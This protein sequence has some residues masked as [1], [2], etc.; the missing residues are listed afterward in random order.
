MA[1][2][3]SRTNDS[4]GGR[5]QEEALE[6][7]AVVDPVPTLTAYISFYPHTGTGFHSALS[8]FSVD[9]IQVNLAYFISPGRRG[10]EGHSFRGSTGAHRNLPG[11]LSARSRARETRE[12]YAD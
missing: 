9:R 3:E 7:L 2:A 4:N 6:L 11:R 5:V 12:F 10:A 8:M 1:I